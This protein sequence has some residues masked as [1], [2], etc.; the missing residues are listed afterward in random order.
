MRIK[1]VQDISNV[2][3][4]ED[5]RR[6]ASISL[7]SIVDVVNGDVDLVDNCRTSLVSVTFTAAN[8]ETKVAHGLGKV[9]Q[10]YITVG[11]SADVRVYDGASDSTSENVFVRAS[12]AGTVRLLVF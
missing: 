12:G 2:G 11:R 7:K 10:G 1:T 9:P 3:S 8:T 5:L 6:Y 4:W